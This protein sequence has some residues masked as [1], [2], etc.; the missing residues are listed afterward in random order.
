MVYL[1]GA[2]FGGGSCKVTLLS[3]DG[4]CIYSKGHEYHSYCPKPLYIEQDP[5]EIYQAFTETVKSLLAGQ[6]VSGTDIA[7]V[8]LDGGTHIAV[9]LDEKDTVLR[10]AIYWSDGRSTKE[11][12]ELK[13]THGTMIAERV[14]NMP[15]ATWT[16]PQLQWLK[17]NEPEIFSKIRKIRFLKDYIRFRLTGD[18][19][20]DSIEAMGSMLEDARIDRWDSELCS[21]ASLDP[22]MMPLIVKPT[23]T[24]G[25]IQKKACSETGLSPQ[26][27]VIA[28]ATDTAMELFASGAV[29]EG[30]STI[31]LATAGRI[32]VVSKRPVIDPCLYTYKHVVDGM[33]YP[34]TGTKTCA[35]S[36]RWFRDN[37]SCNPDDPRA[38]QIID[39]QASRIPAGSDGV[40]FHPYLQGELT[41]YQDNKLRASFTGM[42]SSATYGHLCRAVLEGVAYSLYDCI[43]VLEQL[44]LR[45]KSVMRLIGGGSRSSLWAQIVC[46]VLG[47]PLVKIDTDDSSIGSAMLAGVAVGI[48][49]SC[50]EA[51]QTVTK[52]GKTYEPDGHNHQVYQNYFE[53]YKQITL[54]LQKVYREINR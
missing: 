41:P 7:A 31:K 38:Y 26:T 12:G 42:T 2:D 33:W 24:V 10:R 9:L 17:K 49:K 34:G 11:A 35:A 21:M 15:T 13:K 53:G 45:P 39:A 22:A 29:H 25:M 47:V 46:D 54:A 16:L 37:L 43:G 5:E 19:I 48:F 28:G 1:L 23:E 18:Y 44:N 52:Q 51:V 3:S 6:H 14:F 20:T 50:E 36:L 4:K 40:Y 8:C 32:C 30:D 27:K